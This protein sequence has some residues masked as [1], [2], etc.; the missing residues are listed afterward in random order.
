[1]KNINNFEQFN[2]NKIF[3]EL[4]KL[5][6]LKIDLILKKAHD[7]TGM[8]QHEIDV[9]NKYLTEYNL[10]DDVK[11]FLKNEIKIHQDFIDSIKKREE[12]DRKIRKEIKNN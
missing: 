5:D 9:Y 11:D 12:S 7:R 4:S 1:M 8:F 3:E 10:S 6:D 2:E